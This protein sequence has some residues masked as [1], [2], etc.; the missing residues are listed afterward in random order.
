MRAPYRECGSPDISAREGNVRA[1]PYLI[2]KPRDHTDTARDLAEIASHIGQ[3]K[4]DA[5]A[6]LHDPDYDTLKHRL[7]NAHSALEAAAVVARRRVGLNE[8]RGR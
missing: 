8:G 6:S 2:G 4:G 7:E 1:Y 3:H 5:H